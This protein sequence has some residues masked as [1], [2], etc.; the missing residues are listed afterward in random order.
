MAK[1]VLRVKRRRDDP[2]PPD[3]FELQTKPILRRKRPRKDADDDD[4]GTDNLTSMLGNSSFLGTLPPPLTTTT[5]QSET[6][7]NSANVG[8]TDSIKVIFRKVSPSSHKRKA[9]PD[10]HVKLVDATV[11][12]SDDEN[13]QIQQNELDRFGDI[14]SHKRPKFSLRMVETSVVNE[15]QFWES[16][17][18]QST[19]VQDRNNIT[20]SSQAI[21]TAKVVDRSTN[22]LGGTS[23]LRDR[24]RRR[25]R[26]TPKTCSRARSSRILDPLSKMV[27]DSLRS[28]HQGSNKQ[29]PTQSILQHLQLL[30]EQTQSGGLAKLVNWQGT[31]G[32]GTI[33]HICALVNSIVGAQAT[34]QMY[35]YLI[36]FWKKDGDGRSALDVARETEANGVWD[37]IKAHVDGGDMSMVRERSGI[38]K[39]EH[40]QVGDEDFVYDVYYLDYSH[41]PE[42]RANQFET[43]NQVQPN[44]DKLSPKSCTHDNHDTSISTETNSNSTLMNLSQ[45]RL[46]RDSQDSNTAANL[47]STDV[48]KESE[49]VVVNM[50]GGLGYWVDGELVL[51]VHHDGQSDDSQMEDDEYDSNREDCD[52]NDYPDEDDSDLCCNSVIER[53]TGMT[54]PRFMNGQIK[55]PMADSGDDSD[56]DIDGI[57]FRNRPIDL[58]AVNFG[59]T[60]HQF[61][62]GLQDDDDDVDSDDDYRGFMC[63]NSNSWS[64]ER[65]NC[66]TEAYDPDMEGE[67]SY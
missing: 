8:H 5:Q 65:I 61:G 22:S 50:Y 3:V 51:D 67:D 17:E 48:P 32:S 52:A 12:P 58:S 34:C 37:V 24:M 26:F 56:S 14:T 20:Q 25:A 38:E 6:M 33:L 1:T 43:S 4:E 55:S 19:G 31:D 49:P 44:R 18:F 28:I 27:D 13:S 46:N 59:G 10:E 2:S 42:K 45:D 29:N 7:P 62:G 54:P 47:R 36:D 40:T 35:P 23:A 9:H 66:E 63:R 64:T 57:D 30:Q 60:R 53:G 41:L 15:Q 11:D 21:N 39:G 16:Q